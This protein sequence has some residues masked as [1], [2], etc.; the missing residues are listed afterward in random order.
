MCYR[1]R[2]YIKPSSGAAATN[3]SLHDVPENLEAIAY[4]VHT[5]SR[6][7]VVMGAYGDLGHPQTQHMALHQK[8]RVEEVPSGKACE[9]NTAKGIFRKHSKSA[10]KGLIV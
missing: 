5:G 2:G 8:C 10:M 7:L 9:R 1:F 3:A 4:R 6:V